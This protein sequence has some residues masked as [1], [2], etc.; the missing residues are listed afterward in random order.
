[1]LHSRTIHL[2]DGT[3]RS[4]FALPPDY[5]DFPPP[6]IDRV[7]MM[8]SDGFRNTDAPFGPNFMSLKRKFGYEEDR[9]IDGDEFP[10]RKQKLLQY[11]NASANLGSGTGVGADVDPSVM[12]AFLYFVKLVIENPDKRKNY[13]EN[14]KHGP[15][16]CLACGRFDDITPITFSLLFCQFS[17]KFLLDGF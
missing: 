16:K 4:Y 10:R 6:P 11:G 3:I 2:A 5:Q 7:G 8:G 17:L 14:G 1:M 15:L 13:L 9:D 12:K